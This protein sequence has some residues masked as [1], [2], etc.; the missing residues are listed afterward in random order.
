ML[1]TAQLAASNTHNK[2][3][4]AL[5]WAFFY[6][7]TLFAQFADERYF[8]EF[9]AQ[10]NA[11]GPFTCLATLAW[12]LGIHVFTYVAATKPLPPMACFSQ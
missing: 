8:L 6:A 9:E 10:R 7:T 1:S 5:D 11:S 12:H 3:I 2:A 4:K